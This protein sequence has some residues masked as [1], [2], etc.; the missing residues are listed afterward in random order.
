MFETK[1]SKVKA[2]HKHEKELGKRCLCIASE[3]STTSGLV[4]R[5][6]GCESRE[7]AVVAVGGVKIEAT[8]S[9]I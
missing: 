7:D 8:I 5:V 6:L 3:C 2:K 9:E 1:V 4:A